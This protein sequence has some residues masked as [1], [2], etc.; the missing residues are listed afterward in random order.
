MLPGKP[1]VL[2]KYGRLYTWEAAQEACPAGWRLPTDK[3]WDKIVDYYG[4]EDKAA[5]E[6]LPGG[7]SGFNLRYGGMAGVGNFML[8]GSFA[9]Y[10][11]A[12]SYDNEKAW[13]R[14]LNTQSD[15]LVRTYFTKSY[16]FSVRCIRE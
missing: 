8:V 15:N 16:A 10:W 9:A 1:G 7:K 14:Y 6:L 2:Q 11:S 13:Y 4:G 3:D 5:R 12:S